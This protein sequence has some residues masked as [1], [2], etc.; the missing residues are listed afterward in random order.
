MQDL[1]SK[2]Y[3]HTNTAIGTR[4]SRL[5][6]ALETYTVHTLQLK[7]FAHFKTNTETPH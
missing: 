7:K 3:L 5:V 6:S 1:T 2:T 4:D